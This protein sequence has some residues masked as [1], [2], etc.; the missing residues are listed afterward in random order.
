MTSVSAF[1]GQITKLL[2]AESQKTTEIKLPDN[3]IISIVFS[4]LSP[5]WSEG[6]VDMSLKLAGIQMVLFSF[7]ARPTQQTWILDE[8]LSNLINMSKSKRNLRQFLLS[9]GKTIQFSSALFLQLLT[10][11]VDLSDFESAVCGDCNK[12]DYVKLQEECRRRLGY[13]YK[14]I[15]HIFTFYLSRCI[16]KSNEKSRD[17]KSSKD[18]DYQTLL[19]NFVEDILI[20]LNTPE[21]PIAEVFIRL[22]SKKL[23]SIIENDDK[24]E[25][26]Q[27][28]LDL[29]GI[30]LCRLKK[31]SMQFP[32]DTSFTGAV[33]SFFFY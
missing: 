33:V 3:A 4:G 19:R 12:F 30:I 15:N 6:S 28:A 25:L 14:G 10:A 29:L 23:S 17:S 11:G 1:M 9:D 22:F 31:I 20:V 18:S 13:T 26:K 21:F 7:K 5:L 2:I 16:K 27:L 8:I 32:S 24:L